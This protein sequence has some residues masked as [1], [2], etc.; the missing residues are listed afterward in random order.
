MW[1]SIDNVR[2]SIEPAEAYTRAMADPGFDL[3][4]LRSFVAVAQRQSFTRAAEDLHIAQQAASQHVKALERAL[5]VALLR[6]NSRRVDLTP[7]GAVLLND[8]RRILAAA[9]RAARHARA[10]ARGEAGMLRI[11]YTLTTAWHTLPTLLA[12]LGEKHKRLRVEPREVFAGELCELLLGEA[13]DLALA[14]A[15]AYPRGFCKRILR[16]EPLC[17][18]LGDHHPLARRRR[19]ALAALSDQQFEI[20]PREMAPGFYDAVVGACRAAGFEP[21]LD[22]HGAGSTVWG[23]IARGRG[24][25]LINASLAEQLPRGVRLVALAPPGATLTVETVWHEQNESPA[26]ERALEVAAAA[27]REQ[28]WI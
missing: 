9:D 11:A 24:V 16:T 23:Y 3:R 1:L 26:L 25:G 6:R 17:V 7:A 28:S 27:A 5:G 13:H 12:M 18:A 10:A 2:L 20:W 8:S 15:T 22:E 4:Q 19:I 14:P 21:S